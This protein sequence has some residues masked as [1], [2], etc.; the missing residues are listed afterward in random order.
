MR[1]LLLAKDWS[2][3]PLGARDG[4]SASLKLAA[5]L[6]M[7]SGFAMALRWGPEFVLI[8]NDGY[9]PIL[10]DKHP[11]A[12]GLPVRE[13]WPEVWRELEPNHTAILSGRSPGLFFKDIL[14]RIQRRGDQWDDAHFTLSYS[15]VHDDTAPTG[16][17][18][19]QVSVV[20][21]TAHVAAEKALAAAPR[22]STPSPR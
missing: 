16:V 4:W 12:F 5:D 7:S 8:Y 20:E 11:A 17:G 9:R 18:G 21:T 15:P 14:Y 6:V 13:A 2:K 22:S 3:T 1:D 10:G 19:V